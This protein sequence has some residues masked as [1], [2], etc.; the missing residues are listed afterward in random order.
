M[1]TIPDITVLLEEAAQGNNTAASNLFTLV[2]DELRKLASR[3]M[4]SERA[5]HTLQSTALVHE[6]WVKLVGGRDSATWNNR[7][8]FFAAAAQAMRRILVDSARARRSKK[9]G[10]GDSP[11][12]LRDI[13]AADN[14]D[15]QL[16][17]LDEALNQLKERDPI[18]AHLVELRYF[19]GFTNREAAEQLKIS[20]ATAERYWSYARAWLRTQ[21]ESDHEGPKQE[22]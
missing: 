2:Y 8:H 18:K 3:Q 10:A 15:Q 13:D 22:T 4:Q 21:I 7:E 16:I 12:S 6:V 14:E 1:S 11:E 19:A 9:R 20:T 5:D 17:E